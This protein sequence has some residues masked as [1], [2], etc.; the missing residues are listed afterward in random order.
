M[1]SKNAKKKSK[2]KKWKSETKHHDVKYEY[3]FELE[4]GI[5]FQ[6]KWNKKH[7]KSWNTERMTSTLK[8]GAIME[9]KQLISSFKLKYT[10]KITT[11]SYNGH[12]L[13]GY[14]FS[15]CI[16]N[17]LLH[18]QLLREQ[19]FYFESR[20][21]CSWMEFG[22]KSYQI[23]MNHNELSMYCFDMKEWKDLFPTAVV[24]IIRAYTINTN[25][26][27]NS[28][29]YKKE[30]C[31]KENKMSKIEKNIKIVANY[32]HCKKSAIERFM[33]IVIDFIDEQ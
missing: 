33:G 20:G 9:V 1:S 29:R 17:K 27:S 23:T 15:I 10:K 14:I 12:T 2:Q 26:I 28:K 32:L 5:K 3:V 16:N 22:K 8:K 24:E 13:H 18:L 19:P 11:G 4:A 31:F 6:K 7:K 30:L 21:P 25:E